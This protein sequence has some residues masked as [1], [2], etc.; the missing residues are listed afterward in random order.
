MKKILKLV[1]F[2]AILLMLAG[3]FSSC[4]EKEKPLE[5]F[6]TVDETPII[7]ETAEA[8]TYS[9][10]VNSNGAWTAIVENVDWCTLSNSTGSGDAVITVN[11]AENTLYTPRNAT[12]KITAGSLTKSVVVNQV[13]AT[14]SDEYPIEIPFTEY[15]FVGTSCRWQRGN[16]CSDEIIV[17]HSNHELENYLQCDGGYPEFDFTKYTLVSAWGGGTSGIATMGTTIIVPKLSQNA[18]VVLNLNDHY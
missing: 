11:V 4:G 7:I 15:S 5:P 3:S 8:G 10:A 16:I 12:I 2:S 1:A 14:E 18:I 9:I 17:V 6:L 13:A